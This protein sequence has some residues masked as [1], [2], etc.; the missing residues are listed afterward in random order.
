M[1]TSSFVA[2]RIFLTAKTVS[3]IKGLTVRRHRPIFALMKVLTIRLEEEL[4]KAFK[5]K[6][7]T[8][9]VDMNPVI[10]KM[11]E[12]YVKAGKVKAK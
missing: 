7:V 8:E 3:I 1:P 12:G 6:C 9:G 4:H 5:I 11:I 2:G 10:T